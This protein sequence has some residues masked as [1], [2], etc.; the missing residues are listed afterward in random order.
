[1]EIVDG[2]LVSDLLLMISILFFIALGL[3]LTAGIK[4]KIIKRQEKEINRL[5]RKLKKLKE[6]QKL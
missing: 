4:W 5:K 6:K 1:M 3:S 2:G